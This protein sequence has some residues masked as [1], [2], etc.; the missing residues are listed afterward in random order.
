[1]VRTCIHQY[2]QYF[3]G[4][5][6]GDKSSS[7]VVAKHLQLSIK[8]V[9]QSFGIIALLGKL[10]TDEERLGMRGSLPAIEEIETELC[11]LENV[12]SK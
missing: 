1:L 6:S 12:Y 11:D 7:F 9:V 4:S 2:Y 3:C 5:C 10:K 8:I